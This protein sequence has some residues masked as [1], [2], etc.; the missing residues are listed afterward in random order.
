MIIENAVVSV[1]RVSWNNSLLPPSYPEKN[2]VGIHTPMKQQPLFATDDQ[3]R[4]P[5]YIERT[6]TRS[7]DVGEKDGRNH[8]TCTV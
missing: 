5:K 3:H 6:T 7:E 2:T 1:I 4:D 8:N